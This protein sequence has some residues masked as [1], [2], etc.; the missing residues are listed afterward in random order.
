MYLD[1]AKRT[2][3]AFDMPSCTNSATTSRTIL[4]PRND[5]GSGSD[6]KRDKK[7]QHKIRQTLQNKFN[8]QS[9]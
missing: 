8:I 4:A 3:R 6:M 1:P 7:E 2:V 9:L 5:K